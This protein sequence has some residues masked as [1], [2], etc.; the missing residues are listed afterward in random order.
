M[1]GALEGIRILDFTHALGG[2]FCTL[3][4][5]DL[6]AEVIKIEK[7]GTGD[8]ARGRAP[9]TKANESGTFIM[10]N[11][12]KKCITLNL[13]SQKGLSICKELVKKVDVVVENFS[14]GTMEKLG[15]SSQELC[16][17][18]PGLVYASLSSFGHTGPNRNEAGYDPIAQAMGGLVTLTGYANTPPVKAGPPIADLGTGVFVAL[19]IVSALRHKANTGEGQVIDISMQDAI[20]LFTAI[21]FA[22][23]Y[24]IEGIVPQ[25]YG[26]AVP[27]TTPSDLYAAKDG[28]VFI[29]TL[30]VAQVK[31]LFRVI[32]REDLINSPLCSEQ[33]E[34]IKYREQI[35]SL[36][37]EWTKSKTTEE[38]IG[39]LKMADVPCTLVPTYDKVCNDPQLLSRE[40]IIEVDQPLSGKVKTPGSLFKLSKTPGNVNFPAPQLGENNVEV[41]SA[42]LGYNEQELTRLKHEGI[43]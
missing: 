14:T 23:N 40:M 18:N 13:K 1:A 33:K 17:L 25:R 31:N 6:G 27:H 2:P 3:L 15:L 5:R 32:G 35:D 19:A 24:F 37:E 34:R 30:E 16:R 42:M 11:R 29:A 43:I 41:Y 9:Q 20:W 36:I 8:I 10:L 38:I 26:N 7:P 12:G 39:A 4:L 28:Y 21:E 22:A